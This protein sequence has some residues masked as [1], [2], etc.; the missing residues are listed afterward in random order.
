MI[1]ENWIIFVGKIF[2]WI[3]KL[4][5]SLF[6]GLYLLIDFGKARVDFSFCF[7]ILEW[8]V[9]IRFSVLETI[10]YG[11]PCVFS[12]SSGYTSQIASEESF[13]ADALCFH[14]QADLAE[15]SMA[16]ANVVRQTI[17]ALVTWALVC[18]PNRKLTHQLVQVQRAKASKPGLL[19][20]HTL[21]WWYSS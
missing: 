16:Q 7:L 3:L 5:H 17:S 11:L 13:W 6:P 21:D 19:G 20:W 12:L 4:L 2:L 8:R 18:F 10:C 15:F 14:I 9:Y 1:S